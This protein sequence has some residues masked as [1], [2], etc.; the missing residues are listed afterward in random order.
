MVFCFFFLFFLEQQRHGKGI[1]VLL[2]L[3]EISADYSMSWIGPRETK[4]TQVTMSWPYKQ[5]KSQITGAHKLAVYLLGHPVQLPDTVRLFPMAYF[6]LFCVPRLNVLSDAMSL[7]RDCAAWSILLSEVFFSFL[8]IIIFLLV[9]SLC[10]S[11]SLPSL[12]LFS[13]TIF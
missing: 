2:L 8:N 7:G 3:S 1:E 11:P 6:R 4:Y 9:M 13:S 5:G 10:K 12:M